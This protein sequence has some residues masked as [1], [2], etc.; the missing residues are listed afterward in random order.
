MGPNYAFNNCWISKQHHFFQWP[1]EAIRPEWIEGP[2]DVLG[3]G[4]LLNPEN[5]LSIFFTGN[6][7]LMGQFIEGVLVTCPKDVKK[8][9]R[10]IR[11][12]IFTGKPIPI[13]PSVDCLF[14][15]VWLLSSSVEANF[16]DNLAKK[17]FKFDYNK[18]PGLNLQTE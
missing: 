8:F 15:T 3:C 1:N 14:P 12:S 2:G 18:C 6:G 7:T 9:K 16:G 10:K 5:K 11:L 4:L 13:S 17:P